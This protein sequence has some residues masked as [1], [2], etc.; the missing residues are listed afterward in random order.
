MDPVLVIGGCGG[1]GFHITKQLRDQDAGTIIAV[2]DISTT[3]NNVP[4]VRY[5]EG[6]LSSAADVRA[7]LQQVNPR[8]VFH[9][10]SPMLM[11]QK[12]N[13]ELFARVN[14][15]GTRVLLDEIHSIQTVHALIY[16]SSSSVVH[17]SLTDLVNAT[18]DMPKCYLP[19]QTEF[20]THTKAVAEDM[21]LDA[22]GKHSLLTT[23]IRG[24]ILFGEG[25]QTTIPNM[26]ANARSGCSK[27]QIGNGKNLWDCT[28]LGNAAHGHLLAAKALSRISVPNS[29]PSSGRVDGEAFVITNDEPIPFWT[30]VRSVAAAAGRPIADKDV[31]V[32]PVWLFYTIAV[33]AEWAVWLSS[34]GTREASINRKMVKYLTMTRTFDITKAKQRLG[35]RLLFSNEEAIKRSVEGYLA[36]E[37][38]GKKDM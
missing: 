17:N 33:L 29:P 21:V 16:T 8:V 26:V 25:D 37:A 20:Y 7:A 28:Y 31:S 35:Y 24:V 30:F 14:I 4:G 18:E 2:F 13:E 5:I 12:S 23:A 32:V 34:F 22:N 11:G 9:T 19:A 15:H 10:A 27:M 3:R 38:E 6:D 1:L 36:V